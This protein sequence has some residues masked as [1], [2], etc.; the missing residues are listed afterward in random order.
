MRFRFIPA[1]TVVALLIGGAGAFAADSWP[2]DAVA[3][4]E[5]A[6]VG[7]AGAVVVAGAVAG[8]LVD[9]ARS[10]SSALALKRQPKVAT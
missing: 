6:G 4:G 10:F 9:S 3:E 5:A 2:G 1:L 8:S 7:P